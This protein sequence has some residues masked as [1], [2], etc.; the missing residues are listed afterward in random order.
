[1]DNVNLNELTPEQ[2][3]ICIAWER[4]QRRKRM[5]DFHCGDCGE[6]TDDYMVTD[7]VWHE[8]G[9]PTKAG[10]CCLPC[11]SR[12]LGRAF[13]MADFKEVMVNRTIRIGYLLGLRAGFT[14]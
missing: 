9:F 8:A 1:M 6:P 13:T 14:P 12:R 3:R 2:K 7:K 4:E 11:L 10:R 5:R